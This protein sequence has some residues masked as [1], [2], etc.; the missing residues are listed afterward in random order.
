MVVQITAC[1]NRILFPRNWFA[2]SG[3]Q[4]HL[5][6]LFV[7]WQLLY[8]NGM[9]SDKDDIKLKWYSHEALK[10]CTTMWFH[11]CCVLLLWFHYCTGC[12]TVQ[13]SLLLWFDYKQI[14]IFLFLSF[15]IIYFFRNNDRIYYNI[16][17]Y[18][19][20]NILLQFLHALFWHIII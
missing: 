10:F 15:Y 1:N 8:Y 12:I 20:S 17:Y 19:T 14:F 9:Q 16:Q 11:Y 18:V 2:W 7:M 13:I 5:I 4:K 3:I 6:S